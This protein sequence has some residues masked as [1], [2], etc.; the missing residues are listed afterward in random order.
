MVRKVRDRTLQKLNR[1]SKRKRWGRGPS[2]SPHPPSFSVL[3]SVQ[4]SCRSNS[5]FANHKRKKT[6]HPSNHFCRVS[7]VSFCHYEELQK[8]QIKLCFER[9]R[10]NNWK[11]EQ[12]RFKR[13]TF[14]RKMEA[15]SLPYY[16][17]VFQAPWTQKIVCCSVRDGV[18]HWVFAPQH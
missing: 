13:N 2:P 18:C 15:Y 11:Q 4:H 7:A 5:Y 3:N 16:I 17:V 8:K 12:T 14:W 10:H 9:N 6:P 1:E